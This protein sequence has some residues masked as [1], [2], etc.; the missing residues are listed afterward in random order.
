MAVDPHAVIAQAEAIFQEVCVHPA[1]TPISG[2]R[3][4]RARLP[5]TEARFYRELLAI[6][7]AFGDRHTHCKLPPPFAGDLAILPFAV[8]S[9][10]DNGHWR[11]AV[12]SSEIDQ[13]AR[14]DLLTGWNGKPIGRIVDEH[15]AWQLGANRSAR[16]AKAVQSLTLRP[17]ALMPVPKGSVV[18]DV[19]TADGREKRLQFAW[20]R[21]GMQSPRITALANGAQ[22]LSARTVE[23]ASGPLG[24]MSVRSF[25]ERPA[26]LMQAFLDCLEQMPP[27]GLVLDLRGCEEGFIQSAEQLIQ[28][29]APVEIQPLRFEFRVTDLVCGLVKGWSALAPWREDVERAAASGEP[30]SAGHPIT[31]RDEA[32]SLGR[33]YPGPVAV[34]VDALTYSSAEM[35]AAG[36]QDHGIGTVLGVCPQTGGGGASAWSQT[37]VFKRTGFERFRRLPNAPEFRVAAQRCRRGGRRAGQLLERIGIIP[38]TYHAT[39]AR[40]FHDADQ[41]LTEIAGRLLA[42][43]KLGW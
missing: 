17:L 34:L 4:L 31:T 16:I 36:F 7:A 26:A 42:R 38:D 40:D 37:S 27:D 3:R 18:L 2:L 9:Y 28:L 20:E 15:A 11:I 14:G 10:C 6:F 19:I 39:T 30:Y 35:L 24:W 43:R 8:G 22:A 41:E 23:T 21:V 25:E 33:R 1:A 32:N 29:F 13:L 5:P 12:S